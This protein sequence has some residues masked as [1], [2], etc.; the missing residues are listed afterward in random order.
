MRFK[1]G[2]LS[3]TAA[4]QSDRR[5][6]L[7]LSTSSTHAVRCP[8]CLHLRFRVRVTRSHK[9]VRNGARQL[10]KNISMLFLFP[11]TR[12]MLFTDID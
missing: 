1:D 12:E 2:F 10:Y 9:R 6:G 11:V 5:L 8:S 7:H 3:S 4:H